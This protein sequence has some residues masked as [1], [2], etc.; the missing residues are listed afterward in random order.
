MT[1]ASVTA[2]VVREEPH[3]R[4]FKSG[5]LIKYSCPSVGMHGIHVLKDD[6]GKDDLGSPYDDLDLSEYD[7]FREPHNG[8]VIDG[9]PKFREK[10]NWVI[11]G[12]NMYYRVLIE[13]RLY[14]IHHSHLKPLDKNNETGT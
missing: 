5:D 4:K 14:W 1:V 12:A 8:L 9:E 3:Y 11:N 6:W 2:S 13:T 10:A 7:F